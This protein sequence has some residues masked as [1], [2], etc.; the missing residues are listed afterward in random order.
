M[1]VYY[2]TQDSPGKSAATADIVANWPV[3]YVSDVVVPFILDAAD[4][5]SITRSD[6]ELQTTF[7][8]WPLYYSINDKVAGDI[9]GQGE[10]GMWFVVSPNPGSFPPTSIPALPAPAPAATSSSCP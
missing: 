6:G 9:L 1:T 5:G 4:F 2:Y 8:G 7:R 10:D 3:V